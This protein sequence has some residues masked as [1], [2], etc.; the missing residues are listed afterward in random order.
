MIPG[1]S[2]L[3]QSSVELARGIGG[4]AVTGR[5]EQEHGARLPLQGELDEQQ[6]D[7]F[8]S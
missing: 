5:G 7:A 6:D 4:V 2:F 3:H 1:E 8:S